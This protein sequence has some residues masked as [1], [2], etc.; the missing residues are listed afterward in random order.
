MFEALEVSDC[1]GHLKNEKPNHRI[2]EYGKA[3]M[4]LMKKEFETWKKL[5]KLKNWKF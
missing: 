3:F 2:L 5:K 1:L 4:K